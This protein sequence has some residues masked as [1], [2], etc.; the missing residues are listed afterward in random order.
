MSKYESILVH[1]FSEWMYGLAIH[2]GEIHLFRG[3]NIILQ[4]NQTLS[5]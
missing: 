3:E 5:L 4:A 1:V 2:T